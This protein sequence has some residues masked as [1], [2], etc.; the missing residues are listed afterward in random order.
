MEERGSICFAVIDS[1]H[2]SQLSGLRFY[3]SM[4][5]PKAKRM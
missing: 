1:G 4:L 2:I 5:E 3:F